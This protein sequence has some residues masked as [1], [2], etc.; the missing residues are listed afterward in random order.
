MPAARRYEAVVRSLGS[1]PAASVELVARILRARRRHGQ[2]AAALRVAIRKSPGNARLWVDLSGVLGEGRQASK[3]EAALRMALALHPGS[4]EVLQ[5]I[6][7][8][9]AHVLAPRGVERTWLLRVVACVVDLPRA[10]LRLAHLALPG[11][12]YR[13]VLARI[14]RILEPRSYVEI[15]VA[16]GATLALAR[17]PTLTI[18]IDPQPTI[19]RRLPVPARVYQ[20]SSDTFFEQ[21]DLGVLLSGEML[22]LGF[23]DGLHTFEQTLRDFVNIEAF[24]G[25]HSVLVLHDCLPLDERTSV[26]PRRTS[27]WSGDSWRLIPFLM[28]RRPDLDLRLIAAPPTGLLIVTGLNAGSRRRPAP[29][30]IARYRALRVADLRRDYLSGLPRIENTSDE[31]IAYF[32]SLAIGRDQGRAAR[33]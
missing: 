7:T 11:P 14:H 18:G 27:F 23:I 24:M 20:L 29:D 10:H 8:A 16:S 25:P 1:L 21:V 32:R 28:D 15:G 13:E 9:T 22:D 12:S 31:Q 19:R 4:P 3:A 26:V 6:A 30:E 2:A 17:P 33:V 5:A